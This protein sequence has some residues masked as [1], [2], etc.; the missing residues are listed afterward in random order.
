MLSAEVKNVNSELSLISLTETE[1]CTTQGC[2]LHNMIWHAKKYVLRLQ[3]CG[4]TVRPVET[5]SAASTSQEQRNT[6]AESTCGSAQCLPLKHE[7][8]ENGLGVR[9]SLK[10]FA[11]ENTSLSCVSWAPDSTLSTD[12]EKR[13]N[14]PAPTNERVLD[15]EEQTR[16][17]PVK[18]STPAFLKHLE[19]GTKPPQSCGHC[20]LSKEHKGQTL[21]SL[22]SCTPP[23]PFEKKQEEDKEQPKSSCDMPAKESTPTPL[24]EETRHRLRTALVL[25]LLNSPNLHILSQNKKEQNKDK[26][27]AKLSQS[28]E[29]CVLSKEHKGQPLNS[30]LS[31]HPSG[32]PSEKKHQRKS[33][34]KL[35]V[36]CSDATPQLAPTCPSPKL[37]NYKVQESPLG[38]AQTPRENLLTNK[39]EGAQNSPH[40]YPR[41]QRGPTVRSHSGLRQDRETP[42]P[43][44][45]KR[46]V[47]IYS[48]SGRHTTSGR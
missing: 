38:A 41:T 24:K 11:E 30:L 29:P 36:Q 46:P 25:L 9:S 20:V 1:G 3:P 4:Q 15:E 40:I 45:T 28:C 32:M 48:V 42:C 21:S 13:D 23:V 14:D 10:S 33:P 17:I 43:C 37:S 27:G 6:R 34:P 22:L 2:I 31:C 44:H 35:K 39:M 7:L 26:L 8:K 5:P 47:Y 16:I 18:E 12:D 19:F